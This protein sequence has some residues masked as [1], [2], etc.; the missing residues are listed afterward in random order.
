MA[1]AKV[2]A[3]GGLS[4]FPMPEF[5]NLFGYLPKEL[6]GDPGD[7]IHESVVVHRIV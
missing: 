4:S 6:N 1:F 3:L 7:K 5:Q 2:K